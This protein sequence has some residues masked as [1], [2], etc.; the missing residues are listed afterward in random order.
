MEKNEKKKRQ[1]K[2]SKI[3]VGRFGL[4]EACCLG[5]LGLVGKASGVPSYFDLQLWTLHPCESVG[6]IFDMQ[7]ISSTCLPDDSL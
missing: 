7:W 2:S 1:G 6:L 3:E 4:V 5:A